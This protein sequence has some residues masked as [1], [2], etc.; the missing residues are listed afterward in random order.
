MP[1]VC[2]LQKVCCYVLSSATLCCCSPFGECASVGI[3]LHEA[4]EFDVES[5]SFI[6][7]MPSYV[8]PLLTCALCC[9][10]SQLKNKFDICISTHQAIESIFDFSIINI[11][12]IMK[13]W[14]VVI[15]WQSVAKVMDLAPHCHNFNLQIN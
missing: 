3:S 5:V 13:V 10:S 11:R 14:Q 7:L 9:S 12:K 6:M 8:I 1:K 15:A 4:G 2:Q